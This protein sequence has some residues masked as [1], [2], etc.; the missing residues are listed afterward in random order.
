MKKAILAALFLITPL[1]AD[2]APNKRHEI[3]HLLEFIRLSGCTLERN[4]GSYNGEDAAKHFK[5]RYNY[6]REKIRNAEDFI[7][8][9]ATINVE[10]GKYYSV[11]CRGHVYKTRDW[12]LKELTIYRMKRRF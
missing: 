9:S 10:S 6:F 4:G 2:V 7:R 1:M 3:A 8:Y 5:A 12:L 11:K